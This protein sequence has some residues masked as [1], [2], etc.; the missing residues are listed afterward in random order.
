MSKPIR[1]TNPQRCVLQRAEAEDGRF[2][3]DGFPY[4]TV[5]KL[6]DLGL[7]EQGPHIL[8]QAERAKLERK[9]KDSVDSAK[10]FLAEDIW[11]DAYVDLGNAF[12]AKRYL[13]RTAWYITDAGRA[14]IGCG[15]RH[16]IEER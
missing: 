6:A 1:L 14:A 5:V 2:S 4:T 11:I 3:Q 16:R 10:N 13:D 15:E 12:C 9:I 8:D 7:I